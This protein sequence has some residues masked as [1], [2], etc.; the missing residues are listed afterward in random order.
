MQLFSSVFSNTQTSIGLREFSLA[1]LVSLVLGLLLVASYKYKSIY[2]KDFVLTLAFLPVLIALMIVLING[3]LG[4]SVAVA[5]AFSLV[6][7]RSAAGSSKE[8]LAVFMATVIGL[9]TGMGYLLLA[10]LITLVIGCL[11]VLYQHVDFLGP[12]KSRRYA[13]VTISKDIAS[14]DRIEEELKPLCHEITLLSTHYK[15][16]KE[17]LILEYQLDTVENMS[18]QDLVACFLNVQPLELHIQDQIPKRKTL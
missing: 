18:D 15:H 6:R 13:V 12:K 11:S 14:V 8:L 9:A 1:M 4:T 16:K 7:F 3:H 10:S 17:V 5:G 2:S